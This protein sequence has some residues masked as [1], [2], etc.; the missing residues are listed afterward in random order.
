MLLPMV[1]V[2]SGLVIIFIFSFIYLLIYLELE[3]FCLT[4][5]VILYTFISE[6]LV[7]VSINNGQCGW[8]LDV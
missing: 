3:N 4:S 2:F 5:M 1:I 7:T 8:G 6:A